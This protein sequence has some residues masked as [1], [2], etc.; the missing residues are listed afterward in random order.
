MP[1]ARN[2]A[3]ALLVAAIT[4]ACMPAGGPPGARSARLEP[5]R[6]TRGF[7]DLA[8]TRGFVSA[9]R[10]DGFSI[11]HG[12]TCSRVATL[13]LAGESWDGVRAAFLPAPRDAGE[14]R[15]RI[16]D[17]IARIETEVGA[18]TGTW[19]DRGGNSAGRGEDGQM[20]CVDE[21]NNSAVYLEMLIADGLLRWHRP[22]P[23]VS[24]GVSRLLAPHF[25]ATIEEAGTRARFAVDSW[26]EDNGARP[27]IVPLAEW[28]RGWKPGEAVSRRE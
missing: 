1:A 21:A 20:D 14:E 19:R 16:A 10:P 6:H 3:P 18:L 2:F 27:H 12:N 25:T 5:I 7:S 9:P 11:C 23:R 22:G 8:A 4:C 26:F 24:R 15:G 17:A 13:A 28:R